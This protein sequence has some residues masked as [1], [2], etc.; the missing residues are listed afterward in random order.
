MR[1]FQKTVSLLLLSMCMAGCSGDN[2]GAGD[3]TPIASKTS[4]TPGSS[5]GNTGNGIT[6]KEIIIGSCAAETGPAAFLGTQTQLGAKCYFDYIN[7]QAEILRRC[8][9]PRESR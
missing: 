5:G 9:R 8:L 3:R 7:K 4:A 6:D 1:H 2:P